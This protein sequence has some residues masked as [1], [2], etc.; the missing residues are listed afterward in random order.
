M[1]L[2][3]VYLKEESMYQ[4]VSISKHGFNLGWTKTAVGRAITCMGDKIPCVINQQK[5]LIRMSSSLKT[6]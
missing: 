3:S 4:Y 5:Q 1:I 2:L 6:T